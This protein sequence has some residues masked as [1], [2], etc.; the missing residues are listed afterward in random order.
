MQNQIQ[1]R[2]IRDRNAESAGWMGA[3]RLESNW[4]AAWGGAIRT[5]TLGGFE[6]RGIRQELWI[7]SWSWPASAGRVAIG[8]DK[9]H[10][11]SPTPTRGKLIILAQLCNLIPG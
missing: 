11:D 3:D 7:S 8:S 4:N 5:S 6:F 10:V 9:K 2:N 1:S